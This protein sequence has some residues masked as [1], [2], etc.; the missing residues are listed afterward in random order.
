MFVPLYS[1]SIAIE[2]PEVK[3]SQTRVFFAESNGPF[4]FQAVAPPFFE[5]TQISLQFAFQHSSSSES[6]AGGFYADTLHMA[7]L[8]SNGQCVRF[9]LQE[10]SEYYRSGMLRMYRSLC[11]GAETAQ[12]KE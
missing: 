4:G 3:R 12:S 6:P 10:L 5:Q 9:G 8:L 2:I 1:S 7:R 11:I